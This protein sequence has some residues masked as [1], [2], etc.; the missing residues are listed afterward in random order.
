M[1]TSPF[2]SRA[3]VAIVLFVASG[4]AFAAGRALAD[5]IPRPECPDFAGKAQQIKAWLIE[6]RKDLHRHP[7]L[8]FE[9]VRTSG[10]IKECLRAE[11]I[12]FE[13]MAKTGVCAI[14]RGKLPG[15][16]I[17]IRA[18]MDGLPITDT[19]KVDHA[20]QTQGKCHACGHDAHTT[21]L[22]GTAR[23]LQSERDSLPG[24]VKLLFEPAEE[25]G[26]GAAEMVETGALQAPDVD[27]VIGLHMC[28]SAAGTIFVKRNG[29]MHVASS[30]ICVRVKGKA[31]HSA[32]ID[33]DTNSVL[34]A[35]NVLAEL[36][37]LAKRLAST[38]HT[39]LG[40]GRIEA[41]IRQNTVNDEAVILGTIRS[42]T[43]EGVLRTR[44]DIEEI[45]T[46]VAGRTLCQCV[47]E[48]QERCTRPVYNAPELVDLL[49]EVGEKALGP[50]RCNVSASESPACFGGES[51]GDFAVEKPS[52]FYW[53]GGAKGRPHAG[54]YD[55]DHEVLPL[56]VALHCGLAW[57]FLQRRA[58]EML[59]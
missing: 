41:G 43:E 27:A 47:L 35:G 16:T 28:H 11:R 56:G 2:R 51:F 26:G 19:K 42:V 15:A 13:E 49:V 39:R 55:I 32:F 8:G 31:G 30:P 59:D 50:G 37:D 22:M 3:L 33:P 38:T 20:S 57:E 53:L 36:H 34:V 4:G 1:K 48:Q 24:N 52:L 18:D 58:G 6:V 12:E 14:I 54:D 21:I 46:S 5:D 10:K 29:P 45:L 23:L 40:I 9:E 25:C 7:E 44:T 17:A